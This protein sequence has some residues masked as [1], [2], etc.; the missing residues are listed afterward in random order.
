MTALTRPRD[1]RRALGIRK[2]RFG[3]I[4]N[5]SNVD[6]LSLFQVDINYLL[7]TA[8][9]GTQV[10]AQN[11][12]DGTAGN[13]TNDGRLFR[14]PTNTLACFLPNAQ[15]VYKSLGNAGIRRTTKGAYNYPSATVRNFWGGDLTNAAWIK[16]GAGADVTVLKD[17]P[18]IDGVANQA[19]SILFNNAGGKV[20]QAITFTS[21]TWIYQVCIKRLIGS[22]AVSLSIDDTTYTPVNFDASGYAICY[23]SQAAITNPT[24]GIK[25]AVAGDKVAVDCN[26]I[27]SPP[28]VGMLVPRED[29]VRTIGATMLNSQSR[30]SADIADA[31][32][33]TLIT[34]ARGAFAFYHECT[35]LRPTGGFLITG[36]TG[37]F[38][39]VDPTSAGAM[40]FSANSGLSITAAGVWKSDGIGVNKTAGFV[41]ADGR[42][43]VA[44][45]GVLGNLDTDA[46]LETT[47]DHFDQSTNGAGTNALYSW[48]R[49]FAMSPS[50]AP[51]DAQLLRL[52]T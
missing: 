40:K 15:G 6:P 22:G 38:V 50:L 8:K 47:M 31:A 21:S 36:A 48:T 10:F 17:Q 37:I 25:G 28:V 12:T 20:T 27:F 45:N 11:I 51:T 32:P 19:S 9:G 4:H 5:P 46:T 13:N 49:R 34:M 41:A 30:P 24:I 33:N 2:P 42:I 3:V 39:S 1:F 43:K 7:G 23:I 16:S 26:M 44:C 14:D 18:G 52:T 35:S 29:L